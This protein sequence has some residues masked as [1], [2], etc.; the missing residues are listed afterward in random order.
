MVVLPKYS[1]PAADQSRFSLFFA[2]WGACSYLR[3][4]S[5][6]RLGTTMHT[7][8][9][10]HPPIFMPCEFI[11]FPRRLV[12]LPSAVVQVGCHRIK[13]RMGLVPVGQPAR[14]GWWWLR[15]HVL[16]ILCRVIRKIRYIFIQLHG[17]W[18]L[19]V[20]LPFYRT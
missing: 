20:L 1:A 15:A 4:Q 8:W 3:Y 13:E 2:G 18:Q 17:S 16:G 19:L 10:Y 12:R 7:M 9:I 6:P 14:A 5:L 11:L